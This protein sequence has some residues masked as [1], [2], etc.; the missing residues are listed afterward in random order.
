VSYILQSVHSSITPSLSIHLPQFIHNS[1][2]LRP[3]VALY[4]SILFTDITFSLYSPSFTILAIFFPLTSSV[5]AFGSYTKYSPQ[6]NKNKLFALI[7]FL[8]KFVL[9]AE[10]SYLL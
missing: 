3:Y 8:S 6:S 9:H 5:Y 2:L 10:A 1:L 4:M 7:Y